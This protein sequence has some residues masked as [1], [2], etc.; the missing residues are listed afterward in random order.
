MKYVVLIHSNPHPWGHPTIDFTEIGRAIPADERKA[1]GKE[2][3]ALLAELSASGELVSGLALDAPESARV[4]RWEGKKPVSTDG[5]Y[6]EA[7]EFLAG[8]FVLD[9]ATRERAEELAAKFAGPGDTIELRPEME[10]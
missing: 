7:K 1:M 2:F 8:F 4:Y 5:P 6:A 10:F 3:D 9:C